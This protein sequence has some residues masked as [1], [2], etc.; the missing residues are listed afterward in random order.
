MSEE[1]K[2]EEPKTEAP[3]TET[4][5]SG[6]QSSAANPAGKAWDFGVF[7]CC[8][9]GAMQCICMSFCNPC[10]YGQ[11]LKMLPDKNCILCCLFGTFCLPCN[12]AAIREKYNIA[13]TK[14][15]DYLCCLFCSG[16]TVCQLLQQIQKEEGVKITGC[17]PPERQVKP[18]G[19]S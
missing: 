18:E 12:R 1:P 16:C 5:T 7:G 14:V 9:G 6:S 10:M 11:A 2:T 15:N 3:T 13:D 17:K 4:E 8:K 19:S